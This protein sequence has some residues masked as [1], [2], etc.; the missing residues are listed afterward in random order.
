MGSDGEKEEGWMRRGEKRWEVKGK[1]RDWKDHC[2]WSQHVSHSRP[3]RAKWGDE[4]RNAIFLFR[5]AE[6]SEIAAVN[7]AAVARN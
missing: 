3:L 2:T 7:T 6:A 1:S 5:D 4:R